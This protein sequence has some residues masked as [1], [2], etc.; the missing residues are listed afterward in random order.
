MHDER[1]PDDRRL[2]TTFDEAAVTYQ[3]ARPDYPEQ[4]YADLLDVTGSE[5]PDHLLEV[6]CGPGKATLPLARAGFAITAVELGPALAEQA[7]RNLAGFPDVDVVTAPFEE[8]RGPVDGTRYSLVY[9][10]TAWAW[11]DPAVRYAR[12]AELLRPGGHLAVWN[13]VHGFP[14]GYDPF[15]EQIQEV[16]VELGEDRPGD[17]WPP[18]PPEAAPD[19]SAELEESGHFEPVA[20]RRYVW[21]RRYTADEYIALLDTFSGHIAM[22]PVKRDRLYGEIRRRLAARPDGRL[23]RHWVSVLTVGR[24]R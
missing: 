11:V 20:V 10:A 13:A 4:L 3:S 18:P 9:A 23:T 17:K 15:F 7:R 5:P 8:W 19:L 24:R 22:G 1:M 12:A 6:G 14:A 16:Y 21:G 2:R